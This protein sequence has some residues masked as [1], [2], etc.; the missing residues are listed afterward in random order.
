MDMLSNVLIVGD[1]A[2]VIV[3]ILVGSCDMGGTVGTFV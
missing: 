1:I 3:G 2:G